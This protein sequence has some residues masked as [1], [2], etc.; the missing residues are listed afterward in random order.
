[1]S[2]VCSGWEWFNGTR[3]CFM[4]A[5][6]SWD[7]ALTACFAISGDLAAP[8]SLTDQHFKWHALPNNSG[9]DS[10]WVDCS[11]DSA[12]GEWV[13]AAGTPCEDQDWL[14]DGAPGGANNRCGVLDRLTGNRSA[15]YCDVQNAAVCQLTVAGDE[16]SVD[17]P[18]AAPMMVCL[19]TGNSGRLTGA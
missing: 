19:K 11:F 10:V 12:R 7:D 18:H 5:L 16:R 8:D 6:M 1:M 17:K 4:S 15:E 13:Q 2:R 3:Y 14:K 9:F